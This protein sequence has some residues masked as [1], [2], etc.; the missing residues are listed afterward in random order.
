LM[1]ACGFECNQAR[2]AIQG[3]RGRNGLIRKIKIWYTD[4][5]KN[6]KHDGPAYDDPEHK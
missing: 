6:K 1:N 3:W 2:Q 4:K 5:A